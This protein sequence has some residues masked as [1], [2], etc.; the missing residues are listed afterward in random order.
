MALTQRDLEKQR[1]QIQ[2]DLLCILDGKK[3]M[4]NQILVD[5]CQVVVDRINSLIKKHHEKGK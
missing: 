4:T 1:E 3:G 5:V 2:N